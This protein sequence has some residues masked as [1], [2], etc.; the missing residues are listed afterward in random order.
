MKPDTPKGMNRRDFLRTAQVGGAVAL[1][2]AASTGAHALAPEAKKISQPGKLPEVAFGKTGH[3]LPILAHGGSAMIESDIAKYGLKLIPIE[4]RIKMVRHGY[5]SGIRYFDTARIYGESESIMREAL[6][7]VR[8]DVFINSKVLVM[9]P[10]KVR[11]S[12][13]KTLSELGTDYVDSMQIHGPTIER[14]PHETLMEMHGILEGMRD[15][16]MIRFIGLTGHSRFDKMHALIDTG[17]FDTLLIEAGY[18]RK[19]YNTRHGHVQL[20]WQ[21]LCLDAAHEKGMGVLAMKVLGAWV[22]N[23]NSSNM[24]PDASEDDLAAL[25]GAAM[26]WV[27]QDPRIDLL[28]MGISFPKDIDRNIE[29]L[30]GD[31]TCTAADRQLLARY[32]AK[33]YDHETVAEL[34]LV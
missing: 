16:G 21:Q 32:A 30:S 31:L 13:E 29:I 24:F 11:E 9:H 22:F 7:D 17:G 28:L 2:A 20:E 25:P 34:D 15:E 33:A 4:D 3:K 1:G 8:D 10:N 12:V 5:D 23:H 14:L 6:S 27:A 18:L 19:G 26:R